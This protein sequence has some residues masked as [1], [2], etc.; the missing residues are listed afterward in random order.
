MY[1]KI[2]VL[3]SPPSGNRPRQVAVALLYRTHY[4]GAGQFLF[5]PQQPLHL[6]GNERPL[7]P[8]NALD[9]GVESI[10][11]ISYLPTYIL[12]YPLTY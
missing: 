1:F 2:S 11:V 6:P 12:T 7:E 9:P 3:T 8:P 4:R 10:L 5:H